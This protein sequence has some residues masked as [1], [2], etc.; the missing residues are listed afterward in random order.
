MIMNWQKNIMQKFVFPFNN[1]VAM[2]K[3]KK[4]SLAFID[5]D[6]QKRAF[7][8]EIKKS[9]GWGIIFVRGL[10][11]FFVGIFLYIKM[12]FIEDKNNDR[13]KEQQNESYIKAKNISYFSNYILLIGFIFLAFLFGFVVLGFLANFLADKFVDAQNYYLHSFVVALIRTTFL[14][15][16]FSV[17]R[18]SP[19]MLNFV[20]FNLAGQNILDGQSQKN[21][22][23]L[24]FLNFICIVCLFSTFMISLI[25]INI[26]LVANFF[27]NLALL[28]LSIAF[29]YE[30]L[31]LVSVCKWRIVKDL[32]YITTFL[33]QAKPNTTQIE[34]SNM[35]KIELELGNQNIYGE[36]EIPLSSLFA[37]I[38]TKLKKAEKYQQSDVEWIVA[39]VLG[40]NRSEIKLVKSLSK[41]QANKILSLANR[42]AKGEPLS[43]IFGFVDF[44]GYKISVNKKVLS[45]RMETELLASEVIKTVKRHKL[46]SVLDLCTGS[47]AIAIAIK[48]NCKTEVYASDISKSALAVASL[49]AKQN[50]ADITFVQ[51]NLFKNLKKN[52]KY[53][54]IVSNPPYIK[55]QDIE[56]LDVEVKNYDPKIALDGGE[57]G[58]M[59]Y[60]EITALAPNFLNAQGFL[61]FEVGQGQAKQVAKIMKECNFVDINIL[62]DYNKIERI[63]YGRIS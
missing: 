57:D 54:L 23:P 44:Y 50:D 36:D 1:G 38:E 17:L 31:L 29:C 41:Q 5:N 11:Y 53:D 56:K 30:L 47:G 27:I 40:L 35:A 55:S 63:V 16:T 22:P 51:S 24:N 60:R 20:R 3:E 49:N 33:V 43:S 37:Q 15:L 18:F 62:N 25:C 39:T 34:V 4:F 32:S 48:K 28:F 61:F 7:S 45:P 59:F 6:G 19:F 21:R 14:F 13:P 52:K 42:R 12:L 10:L 26:S 58:L 46:Q 8:G 2:I 9:K